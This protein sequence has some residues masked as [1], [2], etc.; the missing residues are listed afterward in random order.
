MREEDIS[1]ATFINKMADFLRTVLP[2]SI[3]RE[4][5]KKET[6]HSRPKIE[7][8]DIEKQTP[9]SSQRVFDVGTQ[10]PQ[11]LQGSAI[12]SQIQSA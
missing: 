1:E 5:K 4:N 9:Q 3:T 8:L 7:A 11:P 10:A 6:L 2:N 12:G